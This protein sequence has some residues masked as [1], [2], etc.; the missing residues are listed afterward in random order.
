[1]KEALHYTVRDD[2]KVQCRLCPH[3]C[4]LSDGKRGI[5]RV[6]ENRGGKLYS[7]VYEMPCAIHVDPIEK[8]PL[9]HFLPGSLS[10]SVGTAGCNMTC[11]HCQ[12]WELS[13]SDPEKIPCS[14]LDT[15]TLVSRSREQDCRSIAYTYNEPG[16]NYEYVLE[17]SKKARDNGLKNVLVTNGYLEIDPG[18][19]LYPFIDA[20]NVDLKGFNDSFYRKICGAKLQPVLDTL[21]LLKEMNV[22]IEVTTLV[23]PGY[24][25]SDEEIEKMC[26]WI[27]ENLGKEYPLHFSAYYPAHKLQD[28]P[29]TP[30]G[31]LERARDI[32]VDEGIRYVYLGNVRTPAVTMCPSC[33]EEVLSRNIFRMSANKLDDGKCNNCGTTLPGVWS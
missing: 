32:A 3:H 12:N 20:A 14:R 10:M 6:R 29:P 1:M 13:N 27:V 19:Q 23:I 5:C 11:M 21:K 7:L 2:G 8:K 25:D 24:N 30:I 16:I 33:G 26:K 18:K 31:T 9:Y 15:D 17:A 28:A 4:V 22:W